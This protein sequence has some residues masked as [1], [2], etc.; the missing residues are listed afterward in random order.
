VTKIS[1]EDIMVYATC[2]LQYK[3]MKERKVTPSHGD[4]FAKATLEALYVYFGRIGLGG[5]HEKSLKAATR[6][7]VEIWGCATLDEKRDAD[8]Q[9]YFSEG[10]LL[11]T[12]IQSIYQPSIDE[13]AAIRYPVSHNVLGKITVEDVID[14]IIIRRTTEYRGSTKTVFRMIQFYNDVDIFSGKP[15]PYNNRYLELRAALGRLGLQADLDDRNVRNY[16]YEVRPVYGVD[17]TTIPKTRYSSPIFKV[18]SSVAMAIDQKLWFATTSSDV[19][20]SCHFKNSC[21]VSL[22]R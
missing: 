3:L 2:P 20:R 9:R 12:R 15:L 4:L 1:V 7:F 13:V 18:A 16:T 21:S 11:S 22:V 8:A 14:V 17:K 10:N 19:C 6:R 5:G